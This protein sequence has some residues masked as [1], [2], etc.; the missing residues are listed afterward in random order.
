MPACHVEV[1]PVS[2]EDPCFF[3]KL[4]FFVILPVYFLENPSFA[5]V[6]SK[7]SVFMLTFDRYEF[8]QESEELL[9]LLFGKIR[10]IFCIFHFE[11]VNFQ[12]LSGY[13]IRER[14]KAWIADRNAHGIVSIFLQK[15][16]E[17]FFSIEASLSPSADGVFVNLLHC[18]WSPSLEE[19]QPRFTPAG[20]YPGVSLWFLGL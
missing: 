10:I 15:L 1:S 14:V 7:H 8:I 4:A 18:N 19:F 17:G 12:V 3:S 20:S 16:Y 5:Q 6:C 2:F 13:N 9:N 11:G